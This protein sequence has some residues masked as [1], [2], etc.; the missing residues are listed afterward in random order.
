MT[1]ATTRGPR[2]TAKL[3]AVAVEE[4]ELGATVAGVRTVE[5]PSFAGPLQL[6]TSKLST[7]KYRHFV[8]ETLQVCR[9]GG[10]STPLWLCGEDAG[11]ERKS[12]NLTELSPRS[13]HFVTVR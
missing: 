10:C 6:P 13:C 7:K 1:T 5:P 8:T 12:V 2:L 4:D 9:Q 11:K 3:P